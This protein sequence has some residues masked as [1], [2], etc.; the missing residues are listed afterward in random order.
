MD[1]VLFIENISSQIMYNNR[2]LIF[3]RISLKVKEN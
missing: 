1:F 2:S 3:L